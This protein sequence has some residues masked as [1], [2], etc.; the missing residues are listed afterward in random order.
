MQF[1]STRRTLR[2]ASARD[3]DSSPEL[4]RLRKV[5]V[6]SHTSKIYFSTGFSSPLLFDFYQAIQETASALAEL[7]NALEEIPVAQR[8]SLDVQSG[9]VAQVLLC[10]LYALT[11]KIAVVFVLTNN[12]HIPT[13]AWWLACSEQLFNINMVLCV[14][15]LHDR[16][17][18]SIYGH[19][20]YM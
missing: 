4:S 8:Q 20:S 6:S 1:L 7:S 18:A 9:K 5:T 2:K 14:R 13:C 16:T 10:L 11:V 15:W 12:T 19:G 3:S 17:N